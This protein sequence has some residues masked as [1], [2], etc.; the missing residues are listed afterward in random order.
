MTRRERT[1][2]RP[3]RGQAL[4]EFAL[5]FP[6]FL[7]L[8][9][10]LIDGAHLVYTYNSVAQSAR[11]GARIASV[12]APYVGMTAPCGAPVCPATTT[13][14]R[15]DVLT[16]ANRMNPGVTI[17]GITLSCG[18]TADCASAA[19]RAE[20]QDN[21]VTVTVQALVRPLTPVLGVPFASGITVSATSTM[22]IP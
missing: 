3:G 21:A 20:G 17:T 2:R 4:V 6:I 15:A 13:A 7:A 11:Q 14:L 5:A 19:T 8:L 16:A 10:G 12:E 22:Q 1:P 18:G 9:F